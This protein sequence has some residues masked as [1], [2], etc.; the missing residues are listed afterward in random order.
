MILSPLLIITFFILILSLNLRGYV[1]ADHEIIYY[2]S[3]SKYSLEGALFDK[4]SNMG[5]IPTLLHVIILFIINMMYKELAIH[6]TNREYHS[7]YATRENSVLVKRFVFETFNTFTDL[8]YLAFIRLDIT[9]LRTELISIFMFDE[10]R[11]LITETG[12]PLI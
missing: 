5:Q 8:A 3:I 12:I 10:L 11:R 6:M 7:T 4:N 1:D 2:P 9:A